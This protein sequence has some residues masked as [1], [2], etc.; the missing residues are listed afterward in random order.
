[1]LDEA[2]TSINDGAIYIDVQ[3]KQLLDLPAYYHN[4]G[5][6]FNYADG[7]S[8]VHRWTDP[9]F[10]NDTAHNVFMTSPDLTWLAEHAWS[11]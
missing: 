10:Y 3:G 11:Q 6:C 9:R 8:D 2:A 1:M 5:T 7:H 4:T